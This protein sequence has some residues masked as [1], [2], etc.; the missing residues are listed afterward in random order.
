MVA[1]LAGASL[2]WLT[3]SL[4]RWTIGPLV[5]LA[6]FTT[7]SALTDISTGVRKVSVSGVP[8]GLTTAIVVVGPGLAA[9]IG[10]LTMIALW[11]RTRS[12]W[13]IVLNNITTF[14]WYPLVA[15][16]FFRGTVHLFGLG[17]HTTGYYFVV[18][19]TFVLALVVN[20][21][22]VIGFRCYLEDSSIV[23]AARTAVIPIM[24][25]E[26]FS[27]LLTMAAIYVAVTAGTVGM[28]LVVL[29]LLIFQY[30][31]GELLKSKQR[32]DELHRRATTDELTGLVNRERFRARL[33][34]RIEAARAGE[35]AFGVMLLDLDRFKEINDTLGHHFG[36][37]MLRDL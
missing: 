7:V 15:G 4:D 32:G 21:F 22:G 17:P 34:E 36:D 8:I 29:A 11:T 18:F 5:V 28:I 27:A 30:L 12:R 2:I 10:V 20:F 25:A 9:L 33:D 14:M 37:E 31:V 24:S 16:L 6:A 23:D 26:L 13:Y 19:P 1:V 3:G 35:E